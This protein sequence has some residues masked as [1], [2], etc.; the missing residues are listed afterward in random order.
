MSFPPNSFTGGPAA[1]GSARPGSSG[2][3]R[4]HAAAINL[5]LDNML[6]NQLRVNDPRNAKQIADGLLSY[7]QDHPQAV[8]LRQEIMGVPNLPAPLPSATAAAAIRSSSDTEFGIA[9]GDVEKALQDLS[10]NP[11]TNDITPEMQGWGD[12]I[13]AAIAQ[14]HSAA[15]HGL[16]PTQRDKVIAVRRQLGEYARMARFVGSLSPGMTQNFR[17]LGRALDEVSAVLLVML[18]ESLASV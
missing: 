1:N 10:S 15:R 11:L 5:A 9:N 16:D 12:S 14:G 3:S 4:G 17:R 6:R 13:R 8:G 2:P 18:G 7:Y